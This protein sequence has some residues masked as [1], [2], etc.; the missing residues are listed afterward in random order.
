VRP[1]R[2]GD[3]LAHELVASHLMQRIAAATD[4]VLNWSH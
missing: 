3:L 2:A 1:G 4:A